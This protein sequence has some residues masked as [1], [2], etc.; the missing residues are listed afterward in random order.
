MMLAI[1]TY[2]TGVFF[3]VIGGLT[4]GYY[5]FNLNGDAILRRHQERRKSSMSRVRTVRTD[6][7]TKGSINRKKDD[8]DLQ[9]MIKPK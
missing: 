7:A 4:L 6:R 8:L 2:N 9:P 5:I 3:S 1:M